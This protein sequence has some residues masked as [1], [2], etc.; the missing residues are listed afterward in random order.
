MSRKWFCFSMRAMALLFCVAWTLS[1]PRLRAQE[2]VPESADSES[3]VE[4]KRIFS[5]TCAACH[6]LDG[7][8][9]ERGPDIA[10]RLE[11]QRLSDQDLL[12]IVQ[13]GKPGTGMPSFGSLGGSRVEVVVRY[14]RNLQGQIPAEKMPGDPVRG[15]ALFFGKAE[16]SQCH[17]AKGEGGFIAADLTRYA[18]LQ[19][20][21]NIRGAITDPNKNLDPRRRA[22]VVTTR[23]G[24]TQTG[25]ARNEDNFSLQMQTV[26][27]SFHLFKKS[28]LRNIEYQPRSLMP[29][30][31]GSRLSRQD[32]DDL[33]S[34]LMS[35]GR[36]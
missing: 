7:R 20:A 21:D 28:E 11:V 32:L 36:K 13:D 33:V 8:G 16:C 31:Y 10:A 12:R 14:L 18:G 6:G 3:V 25:V 35:L 9:G 23:E 15:K 17:M 29:A 24:R 4:G 5:T 1:P 26:D 22:V 19:S 34:Y 30:D 27:G 2:I